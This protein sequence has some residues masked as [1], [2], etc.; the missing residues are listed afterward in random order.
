[1]LWGALVGVPAK[2]QT[3]LPLPT[4]ETCSVFL[5]A[6]QTQFC[7]VDRGGGAPD[8]PATLTLSLTATAGPVDVAG[9]KISET[10]NYNGTY[11]GP[12]V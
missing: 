1:M 4:L 9:Y 8:G 5:S 6:Q 2:A 10:Q 7:N 12:L 11:L 3:P